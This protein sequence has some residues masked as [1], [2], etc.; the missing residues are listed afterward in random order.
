M[1]IEVVAGFIQ[2]KDKFLIAKKKDLWELP[3]GKVKKGEEK[4]EALK[5]E[6][7]EELEIE[8]EPG[9]LLFVYENERHIFYFFSS[10]IIKGKISLKEHKSF[11]WISLKDLKKF[12]FYEPDEKFLS[13]MA[14]FK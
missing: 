8:I 14:Y 6:I 10:K 5:R 11:N 2:K 12:K 4:K 9:A 7:K 1:K 3:G 13:S